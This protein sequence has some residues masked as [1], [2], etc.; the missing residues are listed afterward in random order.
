MSSNHPELMSSYP[1]PM[2][3]SMPLA[4]AYAAAKSQIALNIT[5]PGLHYP[6]GKHPLY[7]MSF[8]IY[9]CA[10]HLQQT[11]RKLRVFSVLAP[12]G[13]AEGA[14]GVNADAGLNSNGPFSTM[15]VIWGKVSKSLMLSFHYSHFTSDSHVFVWCLSLQSGS[16]AIG[17]T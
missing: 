13:V 10:S 11:H 3:A 2:L 12:W 17:Q 4:H 7:A 1:N 8:I 15:P 14:D 5:C 6:D 9:C 16:M